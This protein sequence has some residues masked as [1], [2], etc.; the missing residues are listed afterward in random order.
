MDKSAYDNGDL[1][2]VLSRRV[3]DSSAGDEVYGGS[4]AL[5]RALVGIRNTFDDSGTTLRY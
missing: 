2:T 3:S 4:V 5:W 1:N